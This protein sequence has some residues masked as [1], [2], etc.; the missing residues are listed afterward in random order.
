MPY[1]KEENRVKFKENID[2]IF[3]KCK[4]AGDL[5]YVFTKIAHGY[6]KDKGLCYQNINDIVG[7]LEGAK[8]EL[9]RRVA[10]FYEDEKIS[11]TY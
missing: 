7:A 9:Y 4:S 6:L 3:G 10:S 5:N 11:K 1:I 2:G 8:L